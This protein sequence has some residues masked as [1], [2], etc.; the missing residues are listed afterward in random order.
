MILSSRGLSL[1]KNHDWDHMRVPFSVVG[2]WG[3]RRLVGG[4][5][6]GFDE[7]YWCQYL[8]W[9]VSVSCLGVS[10]GLRINQ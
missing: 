3:V 4:A 1:L 7:F 6:E 10:G 9:G 5:R 8:A 2:R